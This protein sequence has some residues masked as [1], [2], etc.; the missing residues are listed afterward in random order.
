MSFGVFGM[1]YSV[2]VLNRRSWD[3]KMVCLL[4]CLINR[5]IWV[6]ILEF[7]LK[8]GMAVWVCN[9]SMGEVE[10]INIGFIG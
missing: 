5:K 2:M 3:K 7:I 1:G 10:I 6:W 8:L 9:F 4:K